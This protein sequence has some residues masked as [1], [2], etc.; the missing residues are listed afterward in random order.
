MDHGS[1]GLGAWAQDEG[2]LESCVLW[3]C[4]FVALWLWLWGFGVLG[5]VF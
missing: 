3:L 1:E 5:S 2:V 4:G